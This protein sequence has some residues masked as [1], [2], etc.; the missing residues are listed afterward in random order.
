MEEGMRVVLT[1]GR[2]GCEERNGTERHG[3]GV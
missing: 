3:T 2:Q 1:V